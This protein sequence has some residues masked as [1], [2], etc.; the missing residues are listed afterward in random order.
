MSCVGLSPPHKTQRFSPFRLHVHGPT[1]FQ[2]RPMTLHANLV[3]QTQPL[4]RARACVP[5][6]VTPPL[7]ACS[8]PMHDVDSAFCLALVPPTIAFFLYHTC[9]APLVTLLPFWTSNNLFYLQGVC[10]SFSS[11]LWIT[12]RSKSWM[13]P[14][15]RRGEAYE[16]VISASHF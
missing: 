12:F 5:P 8:I 7:V 15:M 14:K 11:L 16:N 2:C 13:V 6:R 4:P 1:C 10:F 9:T 3:A